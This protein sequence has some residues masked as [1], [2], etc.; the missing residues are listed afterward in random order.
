MSKNECIEWT[1]DKVWI[2]I[3]GSIKTTSIIYTTL[4]TP[5]IYLHF[6]CVCVCVCVC[7]CE[8]DMLAYKNICVQPFCSGE[9]HGL[10]LDFAFDQAFV[11]KG[12]IKHKDLH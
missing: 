9:A 1:H 11:A 4:Y 8:I 6:A 12:F 5:K 7:V 2:W 3:Q 10:G